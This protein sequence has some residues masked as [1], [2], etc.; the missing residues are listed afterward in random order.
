MSNFAILKMPII[1]CCFLSLVLVEPKLTFSLLKT[2]G[3]IGF[4]SFKLEIHA[5]LI[6]Y[7]VATKDQAFL[8]VT[9]GVSRHQSATIEKIVFR[10]VMAFCP[11]GP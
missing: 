9:K 7:D 8:I 3:I 10:L 4:S 1:A 5:V 2:T 6:K 11:D